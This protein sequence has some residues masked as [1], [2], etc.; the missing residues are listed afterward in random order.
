MLKEVGFDSYLVLTNTDRGMIDPK[1]PVFVFDHAIIA[2]RVP[3]ELHWID[4]RQPP[5]YRKQVPS[6]FSIQLPHLL[7]SGPY[8]PTCR[9][10]TAW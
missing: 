4:S 8:P 6:Y 9:I 2:I 3:E 5:K 10:T 1:M 7:L